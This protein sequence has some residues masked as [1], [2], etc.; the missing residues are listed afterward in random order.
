MAMPS[1]R[2]RIIGIQLYKYRI[3]GFLHWGFN[4]YNTY[5][6][7]S[8]VDPYAIT[9]G[10]QSFPSGDP[11]IVYPTDTGVT[12]SIRLVIFHEAM[13]DL[14]ALQLLEKL[15]SR[16]YVLNI[17]DSSWNQEI[18]FKQYP[19]SPEYIL[20]FRRMVNREIIR[21]IKH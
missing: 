3:E 21:H 11:F 16:E 10:D 15:T 14:R 8:P 6:S 5:L 9:D 20:Q 19:K 2:N 4:F 1:A 12:E 18:T 17:I 7:L 13:Q